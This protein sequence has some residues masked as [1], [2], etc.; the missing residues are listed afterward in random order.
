MSGT[1]HWADIYAEKIV[2]ERGEKPVY[3]CA[4]G[5][6]PSGTVHIG[7]FREIISTE[8]V[9]RALRRL[10]KQVKFIYSWDDFDVFRKVPANL[11]D[12]EKLQQYLRQPITQVPDPWGKESSYARAHEVAVEQVLERVGIE[13]EYLYQAEKYQNADYAE[14][15]RLALAKSDVVRSILN[16]HRSSPLPE[17]WY[18]VSIF[19]ATCG[20]DTTIISTWDGEWNLTYSCDSCN[21]HHEV[22]LRKAKGV[23]LLWRIDWPMRWDYEQV[24]FEPAGKEHHSSGGSFDTAK[25]IVTAVYEAEP[26]VTFKYDFISVKGMGGN[27]SSSQGNVVSVEEVLEIYQPEIVRYIFA[28]TRPNTEFAISF[29]L[30]VIKVYEDY[31][32]TERIYFGNEEVSEKRRE[33]EKRSY[34]LSQVGDVPGQQ[35]VQIPFRHLCNLLQIHDG[36][37]AAAV[38]TVKEDESRRRLHIRAGCAWNWIR[39]HA[40]E[41]F[42]FSLREDAVPKEELEPE[43]LQS[44]LALREEL[45]NNFQGQTEESLGSYFYTIVEQMGIPSKELYKTLYQ[46]FLAKDRGPRLAAF[47]LTVGREKILQILGRY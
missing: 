25:Q 42:R 28:G 4:S 5:I 29:D 36:D 39:K 47:I 17:N 41:D 32:R 9:V 22:D 7:N 34:E 19:C 3:V 46:V 26:P 16:E 13:P 10:G 35:P 1:A 12:P 14:G 40:P 44:I 31:D 24:D 38:G 30:D 20:R 8:L 43:Q 37:I 21:A 27:M 33:K 18:P 11:P 45:S 23:K 15:M 6:T 2:R